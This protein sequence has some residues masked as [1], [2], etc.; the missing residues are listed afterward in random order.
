[1]NLDTLQITKIGSVPLGV[2]GS[3]EYLLVWDNEIAHNTEAL[4]R[5]LTE[6]YFRDT[7]T[8]GGYFCYAVSVFPDPNS[9]GYKHIAV[10]HHRY[11]V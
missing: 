5:H 1:M 8:P 6:M 4:E 10:V 11:D 2:D 7:T 3:D 9:Y